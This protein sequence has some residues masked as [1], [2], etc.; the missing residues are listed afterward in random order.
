MF[1]DNR[2]QWRLAHLTGIFDFLNELNLKLQ[3]RNNTIISN[4]DGT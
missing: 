2:F 1:R 4:Y 3:F